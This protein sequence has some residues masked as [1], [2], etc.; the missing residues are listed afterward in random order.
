MEFVETVGEEGDASEALAML[1]EFKKTPLAREMKFKVKEVLPKKDGKAKITFDYV[2]FHPDEDGDLL[3]EK[4][5]DAMG[6]I[7]PAEDLDKFLSVLFEEVVENDPEYFPG[8]MY[9]EGMFGDKMSSIVDDE[10]NTL[11]WALRQNGNL[12]IDDVDYEDDYYAVILSTNLEAWSKKHRNRVL[13]V[14]KNF[15]SKEF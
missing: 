3:G 4:I 6:I 13:S 10:D 5:E 9:L 15:I 11:Y 8:F 1:E 12:D 7:E 14:V 2:Y